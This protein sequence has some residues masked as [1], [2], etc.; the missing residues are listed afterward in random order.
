MYFHYSH[1]AKSLVCSRHGQ[2]DDK[3]QFWDKKDEQKDKE[4]GKKVEKKDC[5]EDFGTKKWRKKIIFWDQK[6]TKNKK[7]EK[8]PFWDKKR[9][10]EK[11]Y[12]L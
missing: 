12:I 7:E 11:L 3:R 5:F 6:K 10:L 4:G 9:Q 8:R 1:A 2:K